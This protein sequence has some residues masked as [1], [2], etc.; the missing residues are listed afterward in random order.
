MIAD[1]AFPNASANRSI[2]ERLRPDPRSR[3]SQRKCPHLRLEYVPPGSAPRNKIAIHPIVLDQVLEHAVEKGNV[4]TDEDREKII[5]KTR[6]QKR[7]FRHGRYPVAFEPW[8][9]VRVHD[10]CFR[11]LFL[12]VVE[13]L[14][15]DGLIVRDVRADENE[16]IGA[17]PVGVGACRG[18]APHRGVQCG[19]AWRMADPR[20][21]IYVVRS[22]KPRHLLVRV[23]RFVCEPP[24]SRVPGLSVGIGGLQPFCSQGNRFIPGNPSKTSVAPLPQHR[25]RKPPESRKR[26]W[27]ESSELCYVLQQ[28]R[29]HG[30]HGVQAEKLQAQRAQVDAF[31]RPVVHS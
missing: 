6:A 26:A 5:R 7:A 15:R 31:H 20:A 24:R 27:R 4:A 22:E 8:L 16:Q 3:A 21:G 18:G 9:E 29:V 17:D 25:K 11:S 30:R 10:E 19:R 1:R 23:I 28:T 14:H 12:C 2:S 13:V